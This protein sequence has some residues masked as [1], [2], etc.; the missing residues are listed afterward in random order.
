VVKRQAAVEAAL[1]PKQ[2]V[3]CSRSSKLT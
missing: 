1:Y 2:Q 3:Q